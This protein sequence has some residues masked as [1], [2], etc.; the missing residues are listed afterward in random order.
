MKKHY[1]LIL[2]I[3]LTH[4]IL[5]PGCNKELADPGSYSLTCYGATYGEGIYKSTN[6]GESWHPLDTNNEDIHAYFKRLYLGP[7]GNLLYMATSG[8][9]LYVINPATESVDKP[10][11]VM[12]EDITSISFQEIS[13]VQQ[14]PA[15]IFLGMRGKGVLEGNEN[16]D[17]WNEYNKG[18]IYHDVNTL[19]FHDGSLFA[20]TVNGLFERDRP[21]SEWRLISSGIKNTNI[22]SLGMGPQGRLFYAGSGA[23]NGIKGRFE[24]IPCLYKSIDHGRNWIQSDT[25]L[26]DGTLVY[27]ITVNPGNPERI[28]IGTSDGVYLSVDEGLTWNKQETLPDGFKAY[29]IRIERMKDGQ[30]VVYAAGSHGIFMTTDKE[31]TGWKSK[32][33]SLPRTAITSII[34]AES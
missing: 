5:F 24:K 33:Y 27:K 28:Y 29:D 13:A 23:Y 16:L 11:M 18:L 2:M 30:D 21:S 15:N 31:E 32:N 9:G 4:I 26:P 6:G 14:G 3:L 1:P 19:I 25:G 17:D 8:A 12:E 10:G 34:I 22:I 7:G 20:G